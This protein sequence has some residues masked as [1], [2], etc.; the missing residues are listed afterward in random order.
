MDVVGG[1]IE[2]SH[3]A[4]IRSAFFLFECN[5][6]LSWKE[7]NE[8]NG[9]QYTQITWNTKSIINKYKANKF[10]DRQTLI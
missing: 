8:L 3:V 10:Y 4:V 2:S 7:H 5:L 1:G 6:I 9:I